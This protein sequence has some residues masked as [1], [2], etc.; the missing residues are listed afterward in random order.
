[1]S[2]V[3][4]GVNSSQSFLNIVKGDFAKAMT[5]SDG[6]DKEALESKDDNPELE[7]AVLGCHKDFRSIANSK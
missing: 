2:P 6:I 3:S 5:D 7:L 4:R 1:S